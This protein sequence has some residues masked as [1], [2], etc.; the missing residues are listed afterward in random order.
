M[1]RLAIASGTLFLLTI[2]MATPAHATPPVQC[3]PGQEPNPKTGQCVI[4]VIPPPPEPGDPGKPDEPPTPGGDKPPEKPVCTSTAT[5]PPKE[6]PCSADVGW[7]VQ[8]RQ[9]Y[10]KATSPQPPKSD[11][12]WEGRTDGTIYDCSRPVLGPGGYIVYQFWSSAPPGVGAPPDPQVLARQAVAVMNLRAIRVGMVPEPA[13]GRI[14]VVGMPTWMWADQPDALTWGPVTRSAGSGGFTVTATARVTK[15]VWSM[16]DGAT[17][18][19]H[20]AGTP[21]RD[22]FGKKSSP[23]CGHTY[24]VEGRYQVRATSHWTVDWAGMGQSG[25]IPLMF[26]DTVPVTIGEAQVLTQ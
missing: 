21:Y 26:S 16:G 22:G 10:A 5:T 8:S 1:R 18:V 6:I 25:S 17:V 3:P 20:T 7:W 9:C 23:D 12:I 11:P 14:G 24:E 13:P 19:C 4:I 15:V 2:L